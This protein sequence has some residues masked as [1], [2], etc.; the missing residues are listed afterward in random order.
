MSARGRCQSAAPDNKAPR[1]P[2]GLCICA[3]LNTIC[4]RACS[5]EIGRFSRSRKYNQ[6]ARAPRMCVCLSM[7][8]C[9]CVPV[10]A[11]GR[12]CRPLHVRE[13]ESAAERDARRKEGGAGAASIGRAEATPPP[14]R[15]C[16]PER[17]IARA[18]AADAAAAL[19]AISCAMRAMLARVKPEDL[20]VSVCVCMQIADFRGNVLI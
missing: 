20:R 1:A 14:R 19:A 12:S 3:F 9:V 13:R 5:Q 7:R 15:R 16:A 17:I 2:P 11:C 10:R 18:R 6:L 8:A 4:T